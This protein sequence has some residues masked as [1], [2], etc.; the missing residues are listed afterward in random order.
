MPAD[1][2]QVKKCLSAGPRIGPVF[3]KEEG[4]LANIT[5]YDPFDELFNE[6]GKRVA[7]S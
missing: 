7:V 4:P 6:F 2:T 5:R 3:P 1:L